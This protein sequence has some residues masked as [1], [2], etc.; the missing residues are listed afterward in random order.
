ML[1]LIDVN[2]FA[3]VNPSVLYSES[4]R[5][6][7]SPKRDYY[8]RLTHEQLVELLLQKDAE[9]EGLET[10]NKTLLE[11][12]GDL[13]QKVT[14]GIRKGWQLEEFT[15]ML[16]GKKS[17]R[18]V[19]YNDPIT[20]SQARLGD[21]FDT[22]DVEAFITASRARVATEQELADQQSASSKTNRYQKR[23]YP[24]KNRRQPIRALEKVINEVDYNGDKTGLT[25]FG[26]KVVTVYDFVPGKIVQSETHYPQYINQEKK[27][28][29]APVEPRI[30][31]NGTVSNRIVANM[32]V[33]KY[34]YSATY[35]RMIKK[36]H[37]LGVAFAPSTVNGWEEICYRKL[38]RLLKLMKKLINEQNYLQI[39]EVPVDYVNDVGKGKCSKGYFW[40][41]NAPRQKLVLFEFNEGR[42]SEVP[43][44]LLKDFKGKLQCDGLSSYKSAFKDSEQVTLMTCLVHIRRGF[45]KAVKNNRPL[46]RHFLNETRIVYD[47][48]AYGDKK[49]LSDQDRAG[50]RQQFI[51]PI[52]DT[53]K[54]WLQE[55]KCNKDIVP[56]SPIG[57]A[58]TYALN[59]WDMLYHYLHDGRL[60]PDNNGVERAIRPVTLY[61]KNSLFAGNENGARR[62]ALFFS[63]METCKLHHHDPFEYLCDV[64]DRIHDCPAH[65]LEDLL[66]HKWVKS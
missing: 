35:Y 41:V 56:D 36:M 23:H 42:S 16:F 8:L 62:A 39:D 12:Q 5:S 46:A 24:H 2:I 30:I 45:F 22:D 57:K 20:R 60:L 3:A 63:L 47:V 21:I 14:E 64:Y 34:V 65:Q 4:Q 18:F 38:K 25:R 43:K 1:L 49:Q 55:N 32:H 28:F 53:V 54:K 44:E 33:E 7:S 48:E 59:H 52:L 10:I 15:H 61:R 17:E 13:Q 19:A 29:K 58:I 50:V 51:K 37:R 9:L 6:A 66:P 40:V 27:I 11:Q 26:T 31:E